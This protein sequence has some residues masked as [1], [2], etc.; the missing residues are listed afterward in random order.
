MVLPSG[1]ILATR[2]PTL[3]NGGCRVLEER[4]DLAYAK[5]FFR[6]SGYIA[7]QW[8]PSFFAVRRRGET[9]EQAYIAGRGQPHR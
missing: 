7:R 1:R 5:V 8:Y 2:T 9:L 6:T 4:Q 3:G